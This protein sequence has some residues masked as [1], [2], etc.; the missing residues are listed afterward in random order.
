M[1]KYIRYR[2]K[3]ISIEKKTGKYFLFDK[4]DFLHRTENQKK[5]INRFKNIEIQEERQQPILLKNILYV[6]PDLLVDTQN[7]N[8]YVPSG[9]KRAN[10][11]KVIEHNLQFG[12][13]RNLINWKEGKTNKSLLLK[14]N[15]NKYKS[16]NQ[17]VAILANAS[18]KMYHHWMFDVLPM[19]F[20]LQE[21]KSIYYLVNKPGLSFKK[22]SL[23]LLEIDN[24]LKIDNGKIL[25][26]NRLLITR[27]TSDTNYVDFKAL[28]WLVERFKSRINLTIENDFPEKILILRNELNE[29]PRKLVNSSDVLEY[30]IN[31]DYKPIE[32]SNLSLIDQIRLFHNAKEVVFEHGS[33]GANSLFCQSGTLILHLQPDKTNGF[34]QHY[35]WSKFKKHKIGVVFGKSSSE[36]NDINKP[37]NIPWE[38]DMDI[39]D[40]AYSRLYAIHS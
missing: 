11:I 30:F 39:V 34:N 40:K 6:R 5:L 19:L 3:K 16:L 8:V 26:L 37:H 15:G 14:I 36:V 20:Y 24:I 32:C 23:D 27:S 10:R 29:H 18:C 7:R 31:K 28:N 17:K 12:V 4:P 22:E 33:A 25:K 35:L 13:K 2:I 9:K 38:I 1:D 21:K